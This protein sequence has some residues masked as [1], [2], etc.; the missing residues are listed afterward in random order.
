M[1]SLD[2]TL[3]DRVDEV[4]LAH[5]GDEFRS[6]TGLQAAVNELALR[7]RGLEQALQEIAA[8]VQKLTESVSR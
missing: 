8:E 4:L 6:T 3:V 1:E 5:K 2:R 7:N